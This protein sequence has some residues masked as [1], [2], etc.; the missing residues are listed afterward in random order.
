[1]A[2]H[3]RKARI[4]E[5]TC[6]CDAYGFPHRLFGGKCTG[7]VIVKAQYESNENSDCD[8]CSC[9]D[10]YCQVL[11]GQENIKECPV[12]IDFSRYEG[13]KLPVKWH[14]N[15]GLKQHRSH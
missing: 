10:G 7:E 6:D 4:Y 2:I 9:N 8:N 12:V 15:T 11:M 1:M 13:I 3:K 5:R 14:V